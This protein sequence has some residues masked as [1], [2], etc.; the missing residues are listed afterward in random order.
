MVLLSVFSPRKNGNGSKMYRVMTSITIS[1]LLT[2][3]DMRAVDAISL[4]YIRFYK[5]KR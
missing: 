2:R 1:E 5:I 3:Q 4:Y